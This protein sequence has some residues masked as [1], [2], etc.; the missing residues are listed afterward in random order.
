MSKIGHTAGENFYTDIVNI[1]QYIPKGDKPDLD[2]LV[3]QAKTM[4]LT[5]SIQ[6]SDCTPSEKNFLM[7]AAMRHL[8]FDYKKCAEY[9]CHA[10][11]EMQRLME[12][13]ALIIIDVNDAISNG[14]AKLYNRI[15][16]VRESDD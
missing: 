9:Y 13:S 8:K 10:D 4:K 2:Q 7:L 3:D 5:E 1:P 14:Y 16:S 15:C 6:A 12:E 11:E